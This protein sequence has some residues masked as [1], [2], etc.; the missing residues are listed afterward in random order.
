MPG[1][2]MIL[3]TLMPTRRPPPWSAR[4]AET[5]ASM[6]AAPHGMLSAGSSIKIG[7]VDMLLLFKKQSFEIFPK[8]GRVM[9]AAED[10]AFFDATYS[11]ATADSKQR[12]SAATLAKVRTKSITCVPSS[13]KRSEREVWPHWRPAWTIPLFRAPSTD[14]VSR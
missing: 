3:V 13:M 5:C 2:G 10:F 1:R 9:Y 14:H 7:L 12:G 4:A 6:L 11:P 8:G